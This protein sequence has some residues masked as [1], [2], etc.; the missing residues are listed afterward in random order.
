[1][2]LHGVTGA[3]Y[4]TPNVRKKLP[5]PFLR[6]RI[7]LDGGRRVKRSWKDLSVLK[8]KRGDLVA[9]FGR[10]EAV[11]EFIE[12]PDGHASPTIWRVRL[13]NVVGEYRDF[14]GEQ[15]VFAFT[16]DE[17]DEQ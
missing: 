7:D 5:A 11:G 12:H 16:P 15:R 8:V 6:D 4:K 3:P 14:P 1:M 10:I 13:Y 17:D 9:D 2:E